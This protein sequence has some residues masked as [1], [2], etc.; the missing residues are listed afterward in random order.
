GPLL[1][2]DQRTAR[3][4]PADWTFAQAAG[5]PVAFLTAY[6]SLVRLAQVRPGD[7]VLIHAAAGG[8]GQAAI[9]LAKHLGAEVFATAHPDK[10][11]ILKALGIAQDHIA[12]SRDLSFAGRFSA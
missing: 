2:A 11:P 6:Y 7:K 9:Q 10:W 12:T 3:K 5:F 1:V 4:L 8:V